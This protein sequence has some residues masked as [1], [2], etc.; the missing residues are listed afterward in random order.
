[1]RS[2][3]LA[4]DPAR[5]GAGIPRLVEALACRAGVYSS[6]RD[7]YDRFF[8]PERLAGRAHFR[9]FF[10]QFVAPGSLVFDV[11]AN[12]GHWTDRF[13]EMG[14]A[15]VAVEPIPEFARAI[16]LRHGSRV[17]VECFAL[18]ATPDT[19]ELLIGRLHVHSSLAPR[20]ISF[21]REQGG[22]RWT[23]RIH[24]E[25][26]TL[27]ELIERHGLPDFVKI[28]VEGYEPEV[29]AG[30]SRP[31]PCLCFEAQI[32]A[33]TFADECIDRLVELGSYEFNLAPGVEHHLSLK[34]WVDGR[35][36]AAELRRIDPRVAGTA[37]VF[38]RVRS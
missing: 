36:I 5:A 18:G 38:A 1:M 2:G 7:T 27:D 20:W 21:V 10:R 25:V 28:D 9:T 4:P 11:G 3:R 15:V 35:V 34:S 14:A 33:P 19:T 37:D 31:L 24:V 32:R 26:I 22:E 13:V 6:A 8:R 12:E 16:S 30:V 29:L 23:R 17:H